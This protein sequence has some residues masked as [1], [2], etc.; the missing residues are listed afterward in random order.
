VLCQF[1]VR[2]GHQRWGGRRPLGGQKSGAKGIEK[3]NGG[4]GR[5]EG[6]G[7]ERVGKSKTKGACAT[8]IRLGSNKS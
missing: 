8:E 4:T 2:G 7:G 5:G 6:G 3:R 1:V